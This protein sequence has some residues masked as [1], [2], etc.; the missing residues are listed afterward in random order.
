MEDSAIV[1]MLPKG[2]TP[3]KYPAWTALPTS[4]FVDL[5]KFHTPGVCPFFSVRRRACALLVPFLYTK[6]E[7]LC[8]TPKTRCEE[9]ILR[10]EWAGRSFFGLKGP[11]K[12]CFW[13]IVAQQAAPKMRKQELEK[14]VG[15]SWRGRS[16]RILTDRPGIDTRNF[17][18][19][20][21]ICTRWYRG[22]EGG[23]GVRNRLWK[24]FVHQVDPPVH[25]VIFLC[26]ILANSMLY[27]IP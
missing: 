18:S 17:I 16:M 1:P 10:L 5:G 2:Q 7:T 11:K 22:R 27:V 9:V 26:N 3:R 15:R 13:P 4:T 12:A 20:M 24:L 19:V 23:V 21:M 14:Q 25:Q 6:W 8:T